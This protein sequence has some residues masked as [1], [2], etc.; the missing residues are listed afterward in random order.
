[1]FLSP[2]GPRLVAS[3]AAALRLMAPYDLLSVPR[4]TLAAEPPLGSFSPSLSDFAVIEQ[5]DSEG[6]SP[7]YE[8]VFNLFSPSILGRAGDTTP[9]ELDKPLA[10]NIQPGGTPICYIVKSGSLGTNSSASSS[11]SRQKRKADGD[12][13]GDLGGGGSDAGSPAPDAAVFISAN[14]CL[15]PAPK[16]DGTASSPSPPQLVLFV[17]NAKG[18]KCP[19][20]ASG[21][22]DA[23]AA[24]FTSHE[25]TEGAVAVNV[26]GTNDVYIGVYAPKVSD[27][28]EG[29]YGYELAASGTQFFH[30]YQNVSEGAKLLWMDSDSTSALLV[31][32]PL[33]EDAGKVRHMMGEDPPYQLYVSQQDW[34]ATKGLSR[35]AC[36]LQKNALIGA[37]NQ[38]TGRNNALVKTT[39]TLRGSGGMPK[40]QF[41]VVGLN[42]TTTYRG[43]IV[44]PANV[45]VNSKRLDGGGSQTPQ[46]T[47]SIVFQATTFNT[48]AA[49]NCK[50]V[51]DLEFCDEIQYAVPGNDVKYNNTALAQVYDD[52]AKSMYEYFLKVMQQ[53]ACETD[54][55]SIYSLARTC[56]DCKRAYKRWLCIVSLPRCE[57]LQGGSSVSVIRNVNQAFPNGTTL[58]ADLRQRLGQVPAQNASRNSFIDQTIQPGPYRE[59]MPCD[60][61]CY[62]VVRSCPAKIGF[63]CPRPGMHAF[64]VTYGR[65]KDG[66]SMPTCNFPGEARTR[67]SDAGGV[68]PSL[69]FSAAMLLLSSSVLMM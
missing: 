53:I 59:F 56:D 51:S 43:T 39:M 25:F 40:Q 10:L 42:A 52:Y 47:G 66:S 24:G 20:I 64:N 67:I 60:D 45:T 48:S 26:N 50:V 2:S 32:T 12:G 54:E 6:E 31:T 44:R 62:Q 17:S 68:M 21:A 65:R 30:Q 37:N 58:P 1:M 19:D 28:F 69:V 36:G 16:A 49:P 63:K 9:L 41:Y 22:G 18:A 23:H 34:L 46:N 4:G 33:T 38:G 3:L 61:L 7:L 57:D 5:D 55:T 29:S 35:S 11:P 13:D 15:Q 27:G 8:S 14:T